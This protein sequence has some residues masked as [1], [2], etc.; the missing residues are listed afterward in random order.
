MKDKINS[1]IDIKAWQKAHELVLCVYKIT[2]NYPKSE[3]FGLKQHTRKTGLSIPSNIAEGFKRKSNID[4]TRF[5]NI[6]EG[7]LEELKYQL[8]LAKDLGYIDKT[9][10]A[11]SLKLA[12]ETG[13]ILC[14]W[15]RSLQRF[16]D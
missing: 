9:D 16:K 3:E 11:N 7:S 15:K 14:G 2:E 1:F 5:Y 12:E 4:S 10:Y 13:R 6:S 8:L